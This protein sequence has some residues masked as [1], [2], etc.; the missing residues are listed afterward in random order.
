MSNEIFVQ[1]KIIERY[2]SLQLESAVNEFLRKDISSED[3]K[4]IKVGPTPGHSMT[5]TALIVLSK[6]RT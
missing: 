2:G 3:F 1:T 5:Y 4:D 6:G